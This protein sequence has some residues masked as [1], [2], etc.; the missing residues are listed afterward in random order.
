MNKFLPTFWLTYWKK[1]SSRS[2]L[3]ITIL[4]MCVLLALSNIDK[5]IDF[6]DH[7]ENEITVI[8]SDN[9]QLQETFLKAYQ[10]TDKNLNLKKS[11]YTAGK[12]GVEDDK[13]QRL[14]HLTEAGDMLKADVLTK[15]AAGE[16]DLS[17]IQS[18]LSALQSS[19]AAQS[20]DLSPADVSKL[21]A[22]A[23]VENKVLSEH[24]NTSLSDDAK[25]L[26]T[27][28]V[29]IGVFLVFFIT[30]N[31][32]SQAATDIAMEKSSRVIEMIV[33]SV[34]PV[35]HIL[36]KIAAIIAVALT[37]IVILA[38]TILAC[39]YLFD[40]KGVLTDM[41]LKFTGETTRVIIYAVIFMLLGLLI[42]ISLSA[43]VGAL[44]NRVE[45]IGQAMMPITFLNI[46][47]FYITIFSMTNPDT[48]LVKI[49]SYIPFFTPMVMLLRTLSTE[50]NDVQI[51][52]G[53]I[54]CIITVILLLMLAARVYKGS[55]F[56]YGKG[57][58][59]NFRQALQM[60]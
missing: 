39:L 51:I 9:T 19:R 21:N 5:I 16:N 18:T 31:Y 47:A 3:F 44:T 43:I 25:A 35:N 48:M 12:K 40:L 20:L 14:I 50:T 49:T 23:D 27:A 46:A 34:S 52:I 57:L 37:Q 59:K 26:N 11:S 4:L 55:V 6:F 45:D 32:G 30:I 2:F 38:L 24:N 36:A 56:S 53:I 41:G 60:K 33:T 17:S 7:S 58:I 54:I 22:Q 8:S 10:Q 13:Y 42:N 28:V 15:K 29:Y 1:V